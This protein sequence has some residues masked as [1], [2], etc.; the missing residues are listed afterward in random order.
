[1]S[2]ITDEYHKR[3]VELMKSRAPSLSGGQTRKSRRGII[4]AMGV[5]LV[6]LIAGITLGAIAFAHPGKKRV[7][8]QCLECLC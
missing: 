7:G 4:A 8:E 3:K 6:L 1:L 5:L 2:F